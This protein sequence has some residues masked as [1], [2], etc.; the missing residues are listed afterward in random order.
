MPMKW[1]RGAKSR[2]V[3]DVRGASG[4]SSG[5]GGGLP[6]PGGLGGIG[7]GAGLIVVI[8]IV[9]I[10]VLGGGSGGTGFDLPGLG[11]A[12]APGAN[13]PQPLP[14]G[15]DPQAELKDFSAYVF[16]DAQD[17]WESTFDRSGDAYDTAKLVLYSGAVR[18]DGCGGATSAVG[19]FYCPA[20]ERVYLDLSFY[21]EMR[22]Q[23]GASG[24]F[25]WAYVIAHEMGHH[26]QRMTGTSAAVERLSRS[27]PAD[28]NELSVRQE[29]QADCYAGVW[30]A[31]VYAEGALEPGDLD[32]AFNAAEA[33]G[34][35]RL[36]R[37]ATGSVDPDSFT[38]GTSEQRRTWF[39]R[40]YRSGDPGD[41][42]TF[43]AETL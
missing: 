41:C 1:K 13:D 38:H 35:D 15:E 12:T 26:V 7:G 22:R 17:V 18:T 8:V 29:L 39:E 9:A 40:G 6:I 19:P 42:D 21:G 25:A 4:G 10:N 5:G 31:T 36:Q 11:G 27:E 32:E 3:I 33:V 14:P 20:D 30:A 34:D 16:D 28:A 2:D 43:A 37:Q 24:D 23:L